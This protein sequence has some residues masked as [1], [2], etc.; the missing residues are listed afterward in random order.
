MFCE[1]E[2][3]KNWV[4]KHKMDFLKELAAQSLSEL[5]DLGAERLS[6]EWEIW[7]NHIHHSNMLD[8]QIKNDEKLSQL[9]MYAIL[10]NQR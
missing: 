4:T 1:D 6:R 10:D 5:I 7:V 8:V 9:V 3:G 2:S